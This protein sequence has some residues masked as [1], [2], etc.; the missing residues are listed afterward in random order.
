M[1]T[2]AS[3][4]EGS[5]ELVVSEEMLTLS[6]RVFPGGAGPSRPLGNLNE[7]RR[8]CTSRHTETCQNRGRWKGWWDAG[9]RR[10]CQWNQWRPRWTLHSHCRPRSFDWKSLPSHRI[11]HRV[12]K[13]VEDPNRMHVEGSVEIPAHS[14]HD[15]GRV[16]SLSPT[17]P[18]PDHPDA[19]PSRR[20]HPDAPPSRRPTIPTPPHHPCP[21]TA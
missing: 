16:A 10:D 3:P 13:V 8:R 19:P 4:I 9:T 11:S 17:I 6:H 21:L 12:A 15:P 5:H 14:P 18:T 2:P 1:D 7:T 20:H